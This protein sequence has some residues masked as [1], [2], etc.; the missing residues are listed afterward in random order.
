ME[1]KVIITMSV[2]EFR[3]IIREE[4]ELARKEEPLKI[5]ELPPLLTRTEVMDLMR[6]SHSKAAELFGREDF[7]VFQL[8]P[9]GKI[10]VET[11]WLLGWIRKNSF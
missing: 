7:K 9:S 4:L 6:I 5:K 3:S 1:E 8:N 2:E 11:E 10:L